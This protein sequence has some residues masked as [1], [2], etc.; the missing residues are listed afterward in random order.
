MS[1]HLLCLI[2][3]HGMMDTGAPLPDKELTSTERRLMHA[4]R[5]QLRDLRRDQRR[6]KVNRKVLKLEEENVS[7][8]CHIISGGAMGGGM[9]SICPKYMPPSLIGLALEANILKYRFKGINC[10]IIVFYLVF[11]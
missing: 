1:F 10:Y 4:N 11:S 5:K 7:C 8:F 6:Q 3:D 2:Q 9:W